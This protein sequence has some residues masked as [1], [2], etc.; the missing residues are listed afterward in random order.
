MAAQGGDR[1][2]AAQQGTRGG[3]AGM[4]A[5]RRRQLEQWLG[6]YLSDRGGSQTDRRSRVQKNGTVHT[7]HKINITIEIV[8]IRWKCLKIL[9]FTSIKA[10]V[11]PPP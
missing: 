4:R 5:Q 7:V 1:A 3:G 6:P 9:L 11:Q 8:F 2:G 10:Q